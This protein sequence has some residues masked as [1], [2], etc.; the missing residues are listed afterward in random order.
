MKNIIESMANK[1]CAD[2]KQKNIK[3]QIERFVEKMKDN[4]I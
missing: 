3:K 4:N 1:M 2:P